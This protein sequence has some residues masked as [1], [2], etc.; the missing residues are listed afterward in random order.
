MLSVADVDQILRLP[1]LGIIA[2]EPGVIVSTNKGEPLALDAASPTGEEYRTHR[3]AGSREP[4]R[5]RRKSPRDPTFFEKLFGGRTLSHDRFLSNALPTRNRRASTARE[6]LR[7]VLLSDHLALA[8]DVVESIKSDLFAVLSKYVEF[9]ESSLRRDAS[10][11]GA[12]GRDAR[13]HPD[14][15]A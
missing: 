7:L 13:E 6:R 2:D 11:N 8:P 14:P 3:R 15:F 5:R 1:L 9:D 10:S 4:T 12:R